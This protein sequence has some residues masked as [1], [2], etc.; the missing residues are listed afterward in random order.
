MVVKPSIPE[1]MFDILNTALL[2]VITFVTLYP[3]VYVLFAS[4]ST[5]AAIYQSKGLLLYPKQVIFDGYL[6]VFRHPGIAFGAKNTLVYMT[7]G[8]AINLLLTSMGAYALSRKGLKF[9]RPLMLMVVLTMYFSGG[10]V[11]LFLIVRGLG[12][13]NTIWAYLLPSAI[14]T[15]NLIVMRTSFLG[16]PESLEESAK[17]DGAHDFLILFRIILPLSLPILAVMTLFYAVDHWNAWFYASVFFQDRSM[18]PLQLILR[19]ILIQNV[20]R[21]SMRLVTGNDIKAVEMMQLL[22]YSVI[23]VTTV[24]VL[25]I[26]PFLQKYFVKGVMIGSLKE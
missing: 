13:Y 22:K 16:L 5:P 9:G 14:S 15:W 2:L 23:I 1:R 10:L 19:E 11:P 4:L 21:D 20:E 18:Y 6:L 25:F 26:Y 3:M 8:T 12:L 24:P 7:I 17:I